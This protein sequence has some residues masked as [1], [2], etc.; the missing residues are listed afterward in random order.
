MK[1]YQFQ[2]LEEGVTPS[3]KRATFMEAWNDMFLHV[4]A[5]IKAGKASMFI[6][7]TALWIEV[8][9]PGSKY[10]IMFGDARDTAIRDFGW[11]KPA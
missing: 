9:A 11:K 1:T 8:I 7:E 5:M 3:P 10:P 4:N 2:T 6:I